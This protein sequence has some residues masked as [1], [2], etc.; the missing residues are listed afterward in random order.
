MLD[1]VNSENILAFFRLSSP[2]QHTDLTSLERRSITSCSH[3][4]GAEY[5]DSSNLRNSPEL[6]SHDKLI[7]CHVNDGHH[8]N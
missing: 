5:L 8:Y 7:D 1:R 2:P 3:E 6:E 4:A